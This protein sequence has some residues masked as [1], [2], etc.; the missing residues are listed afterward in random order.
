MSA[1]SSWSGRDPAVRFPSEHHDGGD[2]W[3]TRAQ[4]IWH[5]NTIHERGTRNEKP[6]DRTAGDGTAVFGT[7]RFERW[8]PG[9]LRPIRCVSQDRE[10]CHVYRGR[11]V[12]CRDVGL[13]LRKSLDGS[14]MPAPECMTIAFRL[15]TVRSAVPSEWEGMLHW[16]S[17][18]DRGLSSSGAH[19]HA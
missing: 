2:L 13:G 11:P 12:Q 6:E 10:L 15:G 14:P 4:V 17:L 3:S 16:S 5:A 19:R 8:R 9:E 18:R 7:A 1:V